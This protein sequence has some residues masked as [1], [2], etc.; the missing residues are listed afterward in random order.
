MN[1][2]VINIMVTADYELFLGR[3]FLSNDDVLF[4]PT[5]QMIEVCDELDVPITFF[6]DICSVWAH[7][8]FSLDDY[9]SKFENQLIDANKKGHDVQLHLHPH[10]MY[11]NHKNNEWQVST[12]RMYL[13]ELGFGSGDDEAPALIKRGVEYL[14]AL[15]K[16]HNPDYSCL[17]FRAAGLAL[18]P[19]ESDLIKALYNNGIKIDSS[20]AKGLKF[21]LD[22]VEVDYSRT[23]ELANWFISPETGIEQPAKAGVMEIPI[24]TFRSDLLTRIG[25]LCRRLRQ[26]NLRRGA[27]I[28]RSTRQTRWSNLKTML[29]YNLRYIYTNP[30]FSF[31]CDTKG[32]NLKMLISGFNDYVN[33]NRDQQQLFVSMINHPKLLF[34]PQLELLKSLISNLKSTYAH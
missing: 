3:N 28:S 9:I 2:P 7:Q 10:W 31:S 12:D 33:Q 16:K 23:P 34:P 5:Q 14:Q 21:K 17:A 15:L 20:I 24:G 29:A 11:S 1:T 8:K 4:T 6:A 25:F 26:V 32:Y 19:G 30:F 27:G 22:T 13:Y 18:Q